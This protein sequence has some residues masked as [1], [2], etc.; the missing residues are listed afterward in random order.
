MLTTSHTFT[1]EIPELQL[2]KNTYERLDRFQLA[3]V[4]KKLG[5]PHMEGE[6]KSQLVDILL[7]QERTGQI[8]AQQGETACREVAVEEE[9]KKRARGLAPQNVNMWKPE[10]PPVVPPKIAD[11]VTVEDLMELASLG[12]EKLVEKAREMGI[13]CNIN[14]KRSEI[15]AEIRKAKGL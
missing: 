13:T 14:T 1:H 7:M 12:Q 2:I 4:C 8:T 11:G 5:I 10:K 6:K 3:R 15:M 9:E